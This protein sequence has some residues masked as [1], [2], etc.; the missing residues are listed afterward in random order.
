LRICIFGAGSVGGYLGA[1]LSQNVDTSDSY[2]PKITMVAR[3]Q[4]LEAMKNKGL[5]ITTP[6]GE[7][8]AVGGLNA[9]FVS[10]EELRGKFKFVLVCLKTNQIKD[11][12]EK[13]KEIGD[14]E[15]RYAFVINGI[16]WWY[17]HKTSTGTR[18]DNHPF[19]IVDAGGAIWNNLGAERA[20]GVVP[21]IACQVISPGVIKLFEG[22]NEFQIG[23]PG[24]ENDDISQ[25]LTNIIAAAGIKAR[26][27]QNIR[28]H[29]WRKLLGNIT[30]NPL[31]V[32]TGCGIDGLVAEESM[33][34]LI[35]KIMVETSEVAAALGVDLNADFDERIRIL[36]E[37]GEFKTSMLQD[38]EAG[39]PIE[40]DPIVTS[41]KILQ[42]EIFNTNGNSA[43]FN[44]WAIL[45]TKIKH[46]GK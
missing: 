14:D 36:S 21:Y 3:G 22:Y 35:R 17:F 27:H 7:L 28:F 40:I 16:P 15:T 31:S 30:T 32:L 29:V 39:K 18:L 19:E 13:L 34:M 2:A 10:A 11:N 20:I 9:E 42:Q 25:T 44:M 46:G 23:A 33:K 8:R 24:V 41:V 1:M 12:L 5:R 4:H 26:W 38:Y 45:N 6:N 43:L 37:L